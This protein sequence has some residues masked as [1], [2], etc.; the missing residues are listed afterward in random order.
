M[1]ERPVF[2]I[3]FVARARLKGKSWSARDEGKEGRREAED[4]W[5]ERPARASITS[6]T[7]AGCSYE[8]FLIAGPAVSI[9]SHP[10]RPSTTHR[11]IH[12]GY[13]QPGPP[14]FLSLSLSRERRTW[15]SRWVATP[16]RR[17]SFCSISR[18]Q[19]SSSSETDTLH[20]WWAALYSEMSNHLRHGGWKNVL[21][22]VWEQKYVY[23]PT[24][25]LLCYKLSIT[26]PDII[27]KHIIEIIEKYHLYLEIF[28]L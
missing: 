26:Q 2:L 16:N 21:S 7:S 14:I 9:T 15:Y 20:D 23:Q 18:F 19:S 1:I 13:K 6:D 4:G 22:A 12:F 8:F 28:Q 3:N 17:S 10:L 5:M 24:S 11:S 27:Y 25:R